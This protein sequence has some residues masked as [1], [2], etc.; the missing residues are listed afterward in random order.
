MSVRLFFLLILA[1][2]LHS[3]PAF[4]DD[5]T[6]ADDQDAPVA[7]IE[8][9][10]TN[11]AP[12]AVAEP[13]DAPP[14]ADGNGAGN[15]RSSGGGTTA[16]PQAA[17]DPNPAPITG[18]HVP[19]SKTK[20][21]APYRCAPAYACPGNEPGETTPFLAAEW[22]QSGSDHEH[23]AYTSQSLTASCE[24][25]PDLA[26]SESNWVPLEGVS[27]TPDG[28]VPNSDAAGRS[29]TDGKCY[30]WKMATVPGYGFRAG[31]RLTTWDSAFC[32]YEPGII[33]FAKPE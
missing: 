19:L 10:T 23:S 11:A 7:P 14:R 27:E 3:S 8:A 24:R 15:R 16:A 18:C 22:W 31:V 4:C 9:T 17:T 33:P 32:V 28:V 13:S 1:A 21:G 20:I 6:P 25:R 29:V 2:T 26:Y 30:T 5:E 12:P